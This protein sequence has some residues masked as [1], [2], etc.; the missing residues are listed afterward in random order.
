MALSSSVATDTGVTY[1]IKF[2]APTGINVGGGVG[3]EFCNDSPIVGQACTA[4]P[5]LT[6]ASATLTDVLVNGTTLGANK[7]SIAK[8]A[9]TV[10]WT[11]AS[12][13]TYSAGNTVE[14]VLANITNPTATGPLY[15]RFT[16]YQAA[17]IGGFTGGATVG[18]YSDE[19]AIA[20]S[21]TT[22]I[23]VTATVKETMTFCV[24]STA[25][26]A[27]ATGGSGPSG[28]CGADANGGTATGLDAGNIGLTLGH[29][30]PAALDT[31]ATDTAAD[32]AQISTNAASGAVV[33]LKN[34]NGG[35]CNGLFRTGASGCDIAGVGGTASAITQGTAFFGLNLSKVNTSAPFSNATATGTLAGVAPYTTGGQYGL[36]SATTGTYGDPL[37]NTSGA[38]I[39]NRNVLLTF[40]ASAAPTTPAGIYQATMNLI[41]TGTF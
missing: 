39:A 34:T 32:W 41:A 13:G 27:L 30:S 35:N 22:G 21:I 36:T 12:S 4:P 20:T 14:I 28:S 6:S 2:T 23:G 40:A 3:I 8:T 9:H 7:G 16:T 24:A 33:N 38:P 37:F 11:A 31:S 19:G 26:A 5:G 25:T 15:A 10:T 18:T 29:G 1:D 17:N